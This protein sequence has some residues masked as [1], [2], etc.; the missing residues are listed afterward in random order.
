VRAPT[1]SAAA[2]ILSAD[3]AET[4][5]RLSSLLHRL[6]RETEA[7][8]DVARARLDA[9]LSSAGF[10]LPSRRITDL[11]Q[12]TDDLRERGADAIR[13]HLDSLIQR[14]QHAASV[15]RAREPSARLAA[16]RE[17]L[18]QLE[19]RQT[20]A[21]DTSMTVRRQAQSSAAHA[22]ELLGPRQTL[23]RGFTMT[24]DAQRRPLTS[25]AEA[26]REDKITTVFADGEVASRPEN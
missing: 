3:R 13:S 11:R 17:S 16:W 7:M 12:L 24:L 14:T 4:L 21:V 2:E 18:G 9:R 19:L 15:L 23:A 1:P 8:L 26:A 5:Q 10:L 6:Q 20:R 22:L 25:A